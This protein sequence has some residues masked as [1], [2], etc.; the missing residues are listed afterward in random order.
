M[1]GVSNMTKEYVTYKRVIC[2]AK[3]CKFCYNGVCTNPTLETEDPIP[4]YGDN[5]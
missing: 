3:D 5:R 2:D 1:R 4:C